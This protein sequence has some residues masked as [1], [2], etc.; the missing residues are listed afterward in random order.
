MSIN[1]KKSK[2]IDIFLLGLSLFLLA[3]AALFAWGAHEA[4]N[5]STIEVLA[6][7]IAICS[8]FGF[9]VSA[10]TFITFI[11]EARYNK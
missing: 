7:L 1:S 6:G 3:S 11:V 9:L 4:P 2:G 10:G 5:K 8:T